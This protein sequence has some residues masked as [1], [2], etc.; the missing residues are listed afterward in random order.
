MNVVLLSGGSGTRLWPLSNEVRSKQFLK[1]LKTSNG[2]ESMVQRM[3][4]MLKEVDKEVSIMIATS[5]SQVLQIKYQLG[6]NVGIS[7][8]PCR[9]DTFPAIAL[10]CSLL[11]KN[12][13][14]DNES[15]VV[16]P[17]DSYVDKHYFEMIKKL[18]EETG[19]SNLGLMG[20][21]PTYPSTKYGYILPN[22][23]FIEKPN[24]EKAEELIQSGAFWNGGVFSFKLSYILKKTK[25]ILGSSNYEYLFDNYESFKKISFDYAVAEHENSISVLPFSGEWRDLGTWNTL[26]E[27][28]AEQVSGNAKAVNCDGTHIINELN[29]PL[30]AIGA[31]NMVVAATA[32]GIL[33][34]K[35]DM[36]TQLKNYVESARPMHENRLWGHYTV[37]DNTIHPDNKSSITK[38]LVI[39]PGKYISYQKHN[40]RTEIWTF[41][42]GKGELVI[43]GKVRRV[44]R[45]DNVVIPVGIKHAI[46]A[47]N[48]DL[49]IIEVQVGDN[50]IEEDIER[51]DWSW[52]K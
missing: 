38:H 41:I 49:H 26:T 15:I 18:S 7:I 31:E 5:Q 8:E 51:F 12:G 9:R 2:H 33:A 43:D 47:L 28:M 35:K 17:I 39:S 16:C 42:E 1:I 25:E 50:L 6:E 22:G 13:I 10:A 4:R 21:I 27:V 48:K 24:K 3:Y 37:L 20:I 14:K 32:D 34:L 40:Q 11:K 52:K 19:K 45:G 46:K 23:K 29:I 30:I 44:S 36:S